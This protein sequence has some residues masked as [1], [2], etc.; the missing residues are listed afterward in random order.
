MSCQEAPESLE[1]S[2]KFDQEACQLDNVKNLESWLLNC[3]VLDAK[4]LLSFEK[5]P[6]FQKSFLLLNKL[7]F[8]T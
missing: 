1:L 8:L 7:L 4:K 2:R 5:F 3:L 6:N